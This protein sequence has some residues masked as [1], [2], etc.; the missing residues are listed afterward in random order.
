MT[1]KL[2]VRVIQK[3]LSLVGDTNRVDGERW[4][5]LNGTLLDSFRALGTGMDAAATLVTADVLK[6][7]VDATAETTVQVTVDEVMQ[8]G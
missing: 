3:F 4:E 1:C 2:T 7:A 8:R 6:L 5:R